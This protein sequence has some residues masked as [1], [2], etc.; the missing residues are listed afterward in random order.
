LSI[1][2]MQWAFTQDIKP[3]SVKFVLV[4]LGDN[5]QHDGLA[6]PSL[7]AICEKTGLDRKTVISALDKLE[8]SGFLKDS[9]KRTGRTGQIK[10]YQFN[11]KRDK[12]SVSGTL[13][14]ISGKESENGTDP[15]TEQF[16]N[17]DSRVPKTDGNSTVFPSKSTENGTRNPQEPKG[18]QKNP[19]A[20]HRGARLPTDWVLPKRYGEWAK[21]EFPAWD[22]AHIR[23]VATMFKNH[24][25]A[26]SGRD[27]C[28]LD[29][30][31]TWQNWC[32]KEP[33][34]PLG[35]KADPNAGKP[36]WELASKVDQRGAELD[37]A[38]RDGE[39][40]HEWRRRVFKALGPGPWQDWLT[41]QDRKR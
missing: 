32:L 7:A 9:G 20:T 8:V 29:W 28:K 15:K 23:K 4:S 27:A 39:P 6:W 3:S 18:N 1:E 12:D 13:A 2:A 19:Q 17:S 22:E 16:R 41:E 10:V 11:F 40:W 26:K 25:I 14:K 36:W 30:F 21:Q 37:M 33:A 24:W 35:A 31:A 38:Q 5:A 34:V